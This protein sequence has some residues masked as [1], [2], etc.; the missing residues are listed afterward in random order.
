MAEGR[1]GGEG[2]GRT[3][4]GGNLILMCN[5]GCSG[6]KLRASL[7]Q[8]FLI[9]VSGTRGFSNDA[10][11]F[12]PFNCCSS[13]VLELDKRDYPEHS[14]VMFC[15]N[16]QR[17]LEP[18]MCLDCHRAGKGNSGACLRAWSSVGLTLVT[19]KCVE[20]RTIKQ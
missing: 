1:G 10:S 19:Q 11:R 14:H 8:C 9:H 3:R 4:G 20:L 16:K 15:P 13:V 6:R 12:S 18:F 17:S 2:G 7:R 5:G